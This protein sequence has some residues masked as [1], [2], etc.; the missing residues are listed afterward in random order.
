M[1]EQI[2]EPSMIDRLPVAQIA[3]I[4]Q[5]TSAVVRFPIHATQ[6]SQEKVAA[7]ANFRHRTGANS[8]DP[9]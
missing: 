5:W 6:Q 9:T 2:T 8:D 3:A 1:L 7:T 4:V